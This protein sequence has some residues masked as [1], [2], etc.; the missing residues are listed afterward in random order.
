MLRKARPGRPGGETWPYGTTPARRAWRLPRPID[1]P[2]YAAGLDQ[3]DEIRQ[4]DGSPIDS[5]AAIG[6]AIGRRKPGD[7]VAVV[8][9]DR[10]G[11]PKTA[12]VTLAENPALELVPIEQSGITLTSDQ[13]VIS[14]RWLK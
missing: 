9:V 10:T 3:D 12:Q 4:I 8:Y 11:V 7:R 2:A 1:T 6:A 5:S 14:R 13:R